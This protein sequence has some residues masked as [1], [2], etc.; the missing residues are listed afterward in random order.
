MRHPAFAL[1]ALLNAA[2]GLDLKGTAAPADGTP[3]ATAPDD[4]G[5]ATQA[6][7]A[8]ACGVTQGAF[9]NANAFSFG[10]KKIDGQLDDWGCQAPILL[11]ESSA[12]F[13]KGPAG[14]TFVISAKMR[15]EW[16]PDHLYLAAEV[17]DPKLEGDAA[18]TTQNDSVEL[19]L[20]GA[21]SPATLTG[22][23]GPNDH[24]YAFDYHGAIQD[25]ADGRTTLV[26]NVESKIAVVPGGYVVEARVPAANVGRPALALGDTLAF[27]LQINDSDGVQQSYSLV[28]ALSKPEGCSCASPCCC[29]QQ[30]STIDLPW[31]DTRRFATL[32][33]R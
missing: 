5:G 8:R 1:A 11:I 9:A 21:P 24:H 20:S 2:C 16:E 33:L 15:V 7:V 26:S 12:A 30:P 6:D 13:K 25:F 32:S 22:N 4:A 3:D 28:W 19:Y 10:A 18:N 31:C 23:Y 27:D 29:G 14:G 17:T